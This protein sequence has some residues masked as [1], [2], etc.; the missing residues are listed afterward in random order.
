MT[1]RRTTIG[2]SVLAL[3]TGCGAPTEP[4][5]DRSTY[6]L[7][8]IGSSTLP[9]AACENPAACPLMV[10]DTMRLLHFR[11]RGSELSVE[12]SFWSGAPESPTH[13]G[14]RF[15]ARIDHELLLINPCPTGA[16]CQAIFATT[17]FQIR[18]DS[19][20]EAGTPHLPRL[21]RRVSSF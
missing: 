6:V 19:L 20:I 15:S 3:G 11:A 16:F 7:T 12:R 2:L 1:I 8:Q 17:V 4:D 18:G 21:Y 13:S 10:A 5:P 14:G 9:A